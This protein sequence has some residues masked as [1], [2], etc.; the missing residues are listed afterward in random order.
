MVSV[1]SSSLISTLLFQIKS[2]QLSF[3]FSNTQ[4]EGKSTKT[5]LK[6]FNKKMLSFGNLLELIN[7]QVLINEI[8]NYL[9]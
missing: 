5:Y 7:I 1:W 3:F 9:L 4:L 8:Y 6:R 2:A